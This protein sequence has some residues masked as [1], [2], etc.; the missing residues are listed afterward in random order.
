M[1]N[2]VFLIMIILSATG[3]IISV[4]LKE[5]NIIQLITVEFMLI[6]LL[7]TILILAK[8]KDS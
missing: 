7:I 3:I 2:L 5:Q 6:C 1:K 4:Y 8:S